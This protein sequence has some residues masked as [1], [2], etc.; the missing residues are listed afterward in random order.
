MCSMPL[1]ELVKSLSASTPA[2]PSSTP[3]SDPTSSTTPAPN[4]VLSSLSYP[5][6]TKPKT[7]VWGC[8]KGAEICCGTDCCPAPESSSSHNGSSIGTIIFLYA[9]GY[10]IAHFFTNESI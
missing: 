5:N 2:T 3:S 10:F 6:G 4:Q 8:R 1:D 9:A 7:V